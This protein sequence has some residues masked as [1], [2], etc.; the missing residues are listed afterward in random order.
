M[1]I[2]VCG[3]AFLSW[4]LVVSVIVVVIGFFDFDT[5]PTTITTSTFVEGVIFGTEH[6]LQQK[7]A[8]DRFASA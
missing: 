5:L 3:L 4:L 8:A 1:K 6:V 2:A 7:P